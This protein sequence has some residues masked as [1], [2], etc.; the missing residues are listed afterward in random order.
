MFHAKDGLYFELTYDGS[1]ILTVKPDDA[2]NAVTYKSVTFSA[3]EWD[4]IVRLT[5]EPAPVAV[6]PPEPE[7]VASP[8]ADTLPI[9]VVEKLEYPPEES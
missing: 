3:E 2:E 5:R 7:P 9:S 8:E 4:G 6:T 1:V